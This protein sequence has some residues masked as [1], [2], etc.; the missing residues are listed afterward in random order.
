MEF[1]VTGLIILAV[2][3]IL[4]KNLKKSSKGQCSGCSGC[5][6]N[7]GSCSFSSKKH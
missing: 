3:F 2:I 4:C 7:S 5:S 6:K 1:L